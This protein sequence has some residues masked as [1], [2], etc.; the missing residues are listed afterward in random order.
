MRGNDK[1]PGKARG[2]EIFLLDQLSGFVKEDGQS[3]Y[4]IRRKAEKRAF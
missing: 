1:F 2:R 3:K 4:E